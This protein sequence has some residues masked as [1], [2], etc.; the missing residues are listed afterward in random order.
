MRHVIASLLVAGCVSST[1]LAFQARG[2][3]CRGQGVRTAD[4]RSRDEGLD[5]RRQGRSRAREAK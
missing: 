3:C 5:G 4:P 1:G 2:W